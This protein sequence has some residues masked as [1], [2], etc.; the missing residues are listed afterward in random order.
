MVDDLPDDTDPVAYVI[1]VNLARRHLNESQRSFIAG[2]L[3]TTKLGANQFTGKVVT[4]GDAAKMFSVSEASVKTAKSVV[5]KAAPEI[6][7]KV[8]KGEVRLGALKDIIT[9]PQHQQDAELNRLKAEAET[10]R[11]AKKKAANTPKVAPANQPMAEVDEL[12]KKWDSLSVVQRRS[13]VGMVKT[14]ITE[15]LQRA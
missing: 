9:K 12:K 5:E 15:L 7:A 11:E 3:V 1:S 10:K 8:E 2:K 14:E 6:K 4:I 13:F